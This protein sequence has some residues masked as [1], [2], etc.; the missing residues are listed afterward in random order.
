MLHENPPLFEVS[1]DALIAVDERGAIRLTNR[2]AEELFGYERNELLGHSIEMLVPQQL[3]AR[4][5]QHRAEYAKNPRVRPMGIGL[6]LAGVCKN[7]SEFPVEISLGPFQG[8]GRLLTMCAVRDISERKK[9]ER[10]LELALSELQERTEAYE[11]AHRIAQRLQEAFLFEDLPRIEH[12][13]FDATYNAAEEASRVGGDWYGVQA[14]PD[15]R[16]FFS[17]GDVAG[18][19]LQSAVLMERVRQTMLA[20]SMHAPDPAFVLR[21][22]N[23]V[24]RI[25]GDAMVTALCGFIEPSTRA[26]EFASAGH[27]LPLLVSADG[28][29]AYLGGRGAPLGVVEDPRCANTPLRVEAGSSLVLYTDGILEFNRDI[30]GAEERLREIARRAV[31]AGAEHLASTIF[32]R[33]L[34]E[35]EAHDDIVVFVITFS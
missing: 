14:L 10:R 5:E 13:T 25:R 2:R 31:I 19:G 6:E 18:S 24:L 28:E 26:I 22:V 34:G 29:A 30:L 3:R 20:L 8:D 23:E 15:G 12:L 16:V 9:R 11:R 35:A 21:E 1:P 7:G 4:H 17:V 32:S 33:M 27:P